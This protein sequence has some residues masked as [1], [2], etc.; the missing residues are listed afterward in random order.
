MRDLFAM[1]AA[2]A[3]CCVSG[4]LAQTLTVETARGA[5]IVLRVEVG[6][7][8][9]FAEFVVLLLALFVGEDRIGGRN[10]LEFLLGFYVALV[11]V[12]MELLR[13]T[14]I[15]LLDLSRISGPRNTEFSI[16]ILALLAIHL[17][18][19]AS[20]GRLARGRLAQR[21]CFAQAHR[22]RQ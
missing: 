16:R 18:F 21:P 11:P 19:V 12:R 4:A 22:K 3:F 15:C 5:P 2:F 8:C 1:A 17:C 6:I 7:E 14:A 9:N 10:P 20:S 13:E